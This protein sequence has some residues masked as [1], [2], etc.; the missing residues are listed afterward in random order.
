MAK[1]TKLICEMCYGT[2]SLVTEY[3]ISA[4][5]FDSINKRKLWMCECCAGERVEKPYL[6]T[7]EDAEDA[8]S[9]G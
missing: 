4:V 3:V 2:S 6:F 8:I 1:P 9:R 7:K 5:H